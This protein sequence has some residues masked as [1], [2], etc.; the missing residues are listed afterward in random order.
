MA[1]QYINISVLISGNGTNMEHLVK[2]LHNKTLSHAINSGNIKARHSAD[3]I[4]CMDNLGIN[5]PTFRFLEII[6][7]KNAKGLE[8]AKNLGIPTC[9]IE[10]SKNKRAEFDRKLAG[11]LSTLYDRDG[12]EFV[13]L[14]GF[15]WILGDE[16]FSSIPKS[17][18]ILNIHPSILPLHKGAGAI[19]KSFYDDNAFGGVSVHYVSKEVDSGEIILQERLEKIAGESLESYEARIHKLEHRIYLEA[20]LRVISQSPL[21]KAPHDLK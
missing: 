6:A 5:N 4:P 3:K 1:G 12:L 14:A 9:T 2:N 19:E 7:N 18:K 15:M 21:L 8:R 11:H 10:S 13:L 16:F 17:L 20:L